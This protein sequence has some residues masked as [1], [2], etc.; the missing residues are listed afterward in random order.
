MIN[1]SNDHVQKVD[2]KKSDHWLIILT[3]CSFISLGIWIAITVRIKSF[4]QSNSQS[5][6]LDDSTFQ[7][8]AVPLKLPSE[9]RLQLNR[10]RFAHS[11]A[12]VLWQVIHLAKKLTSLQMR[13]RVFIG[14]E[15]RSRGEFI[16]PSTRKL[17]T[18]D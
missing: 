13:L 16:F 12:L 9:I 18:K 10:S 14:E 17:N 3:E 1:Q 5:V 7:K 4:V 8:C 6:R 2:K 11:A 15:G